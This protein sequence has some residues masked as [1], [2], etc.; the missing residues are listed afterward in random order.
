MKGLSGKTWICIIVIALA[1]LGLWAALIGGA[2]GGMVAVISVDGVEVR[3]LDLSA[4]TGEMD[5]EI[6]TGRGVNTV[7]VRNG[8]ICVSR[9]D[10]PDQVCVRRGW[11]RG[12]AMPI[13]CLPHRLV[14]ELTQGGDDMA[15]DAV[16]G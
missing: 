7:T 8:A 11:L 6:D 5:F 10:C 16:A 3:R 12:G 13:V 9:A 14:I 4:A 2:D 15:P 1:A